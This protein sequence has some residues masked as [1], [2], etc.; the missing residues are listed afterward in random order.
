MLNKDN[1][2]ELLDFLLTLSSDYIYDELGKLSIETLENLA[3]RHSIY[4]R[5][6][7][8]PRESRILV[9]QILCE[10]AVKLNKNFEWNQENKTRFL[11]INDKLTSVFKSAYEEGLS[12][13]NEL[14]KR[15]Q[16]NDIFIK[17]YE[18]E[19]IVMPYFKCMY[20]DD[21][22]GISCEELEIAFNCDNRFAFLL[23]EPDYYPIND[24][25]NH[26]SINPSSIGNECV[27]IFLDTS[28]NWNI[29]RLA[30]VFPNNYIGY[31]I[32]SLLNHNWSFK[33][34]INIGKIWADVKVTHQH[35]TIKNIC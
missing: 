7:A 27:S 14:E 13:A 19:I 35:Y 22:G 23:C 33:D 15:M 17:D 21:L 26:S 16:N 28:L 34:I 25:I 2:K 4:L 9:Q 12:V 18:I 8:I 32:Y 20:K 11:L 10:R 1:P 5:V 29:Q 30:D 31:A 24:V 6:E 3:C